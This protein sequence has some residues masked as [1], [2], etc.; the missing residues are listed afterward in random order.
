MAQIAPIALF[1]YNRPNHTRLTI[2]ALLINKLAQESDLYIFSDAP[3]NDLARK[4]VAEV[5]SYIKTISGFKKITIIERD[6]NWGLAKSII[7]GVTT[8]CSQYG[9]VIVLEDDIV[10]NQF[11]LSFMNM[12]L[13]K[14]A[15]EPSVWHISGWNYPIDS[16]GLKDAFFW[17]FMNCW[18]WATWND[19]WV[20]YEK[21]PKHLIDTWTN[22]DIK[23]FNLSGA[24]N[25][26]WQVKA[27]YAGKLNT[28]AI[29][30]YATIFKHNGLCLNPSISMVENIGLDGTGENCGVSN[31]F[32]AKKLGSKQI[33]LPNEIQE[34]T[35]ALNRIILFY[36][37][38]NNLINK[39]KRILTAISNLLT[40]YL[41]S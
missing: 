31:I 30:W 24:Q 28:W 26:W 20:N 14:Y 27:N 15:L 11:F 1:V 19:R 9:R 21:N 8:L 18:G 12:A 23:R 25:A 6:T 40:K 5:R 39:S 36:K 33:E 35:L 29:F 41:K 3:K 34:S 17:R 7:G 2:E 16:G 10:T 32:D 13:E 38:S 37:S 4:A 22:A